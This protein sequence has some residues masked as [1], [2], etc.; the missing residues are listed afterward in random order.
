MSEIVV[1]CCR[2]VIN[3][4]DGC[5]FRICWSM[6]VSKY[7]FVWVVHRHR[8]DFRDCYA[9]PEKSGQF[10]DKTKQCCI[11]FKGAME[12]CQRFALSSCDFRAQNPFSL[13][14]LAKVK[15]DS[16]KGTRKKQTLWQFTTRHESTMSWN[17]TTISKKSRHFHFLWLD[18]SSIVI[19]RHDNLWHFYDN[20]YTQDR[21]TMT[22]RDVTEFCALF[23]ARKSGCFLH[24]LGR[25]PYE[26]RQKPKL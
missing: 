19:N 24:I 3:C 2:N 18:S 9:H 17:I 22:A 13:W 7:N 5:R 16:W 20:L 10:G 26:I 11:A 21:K 8:G 23:S 12:N 4:R 1:S 25:F 14:E 15:R 6:L